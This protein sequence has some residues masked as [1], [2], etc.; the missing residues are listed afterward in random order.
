MPADGLQVIRSQL[1]DKEETKQ[2]N[3]VYVVVSLS[4]PQPQKKM[5]EENG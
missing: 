2:G 4:T 5:S 3:E 1:E